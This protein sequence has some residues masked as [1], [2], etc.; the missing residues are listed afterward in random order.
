MLVV[1]IIV[2]L[3]GF[4]INK[5]SDPIGT[6]RDAKIKADINSFAT[7]LMMYQSSNG[8]LPTTSQ[9]LKALMTKPEGEPHPREWRQLFKEMPLDPYG[10]EYQYV[11]P[12]THNPDSYDIFSAGPNRTPGDVDDLGN[13]KK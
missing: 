2:L 12:G 9:G 8:F 1:M 6:A 11:Q 10:M 7:T 3:L 13:W 5:L 4:A